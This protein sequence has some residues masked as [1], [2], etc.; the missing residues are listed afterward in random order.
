MEKLEVIR[1]MSEPI[2]TSKTNLYREIYRQ[3]YGHDWTKCFCGN[4]WKNFT[5]ECLRYASRLKNDEKPS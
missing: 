1:I 3:G 2:Q 5:N 4:G